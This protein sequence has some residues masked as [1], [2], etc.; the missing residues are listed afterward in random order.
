MIFFHEKK[1]DGGAENWGDKNGFAHRVPFD[2]HC[3]VPPSLRVASHGQ[4]Q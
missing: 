3:I 1:Y 2:F 4:M